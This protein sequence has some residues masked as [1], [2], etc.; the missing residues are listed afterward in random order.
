MQSK[1]ICLKSVES[2]LIYDI[3]DLLNDIGVLLQYQ[4]K[5]KNSY[6]GALVSN[7]TE[8]LSSSFIEEE[9]DGQIYYLVDSETA[10]DKFK[11][12]IPKLYGICSYLMQYSINRALK[13][14]ATEIHETIKPLFEYY[15]VR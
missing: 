3:D 14:I 10:Y 4:N 15:F 13:F 5:F 11:E 7:L 2:D 8:T 12:L 6:L 1:N 9:A